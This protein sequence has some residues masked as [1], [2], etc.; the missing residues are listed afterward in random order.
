LRSV[1]LFTV[2]A[3]VAA[4]A[5]AAAPAAH[6]TASPATGAAPLIVGFDTARSSAGTLAEHLLFVGNG[7][8]VS[9][10]MAAQ[11]S[12]YNYAVP[13]FY[14]A[15]TWLR[16]GDGVAL[17]QPVPISVARASDGLAPPTA[18]VNVA[19]TTD[20][21][22]FA[23]MATVTAGAG[24]P[25]AAERWDFGDG[26]GDSA[27]MPFH[28]YAQPGIYQAALVATTRA[29]MPL[30]GRAIVVA[31]DVGGAL[32]PSLLVAASPEDTSLLSP[33]TVTAYVEGVAPDAKITSATVA[34]PDF[35]DAS[36]TLT[37]TS[38][39]L[40]LTSEHAVAAPGYYD[41]P[42]TVQLAAAPAPLV[43]SVHLTVANVDGS[44]PS[45]VLLTPP[46]STATAGVA[47]SPGTAT[48]ALAVAG[49]GPFAFGAASPSPAELRVDGDGH[50]SWTPT[51]GE[52]GYQ[53]LAVRIVDAQGTETTASWVVTV[54]ENESGCAVAGRAATAPSPWLLA[55]VVAALALRRRVTA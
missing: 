22:T 25:I 52:V 12:N 6:L 2:A 11:M 48:G 29:G 28:A 41:L 36:P 7:E 18:T 45:P 15:L 53:R 35:I 21:L 17:S 51:H 37:P 20:P 54:A 3:L 14:L 44:S 19:A 9:L 26:S 4:R 46:A 27:A 16:D 30:Y 55:L 47:Y 32:P 39:G 40:T 34:W 1:R 38:A 5:A 10:P 24:D 42:V 8:A 33:V 31:R 13:G 49:Q 43:G 50:V 23:F